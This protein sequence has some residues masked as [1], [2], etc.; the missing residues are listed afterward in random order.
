[1][2]FLHFGTCYYHPIRYAI[3]NGMR[4]MDPGFGGE[5]KL[6]RG[7]EISPAYHYIKFH[8]ATER[9]VAYSILNQIQ[10]QAAKGKKDW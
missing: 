6:Y 2:S 8:G 4:S 9:R 10:T 3:D 1:M 5:H 7:Y